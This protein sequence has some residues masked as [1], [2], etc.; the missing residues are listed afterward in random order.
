MGEEIIRFDFFTLK[1]F[2]AV[3]EELAIGKAAEREGIVASAASK[4]IAD[5]ESAL[6]T[7]LLYRRPRGVTLTPAGDALFHHARNILRSLEQM[8][9]ELSEYRAGVKGHVRIFA[10]LSAIVQFLP[11]DLSTFLR[12]HPMVKIDLEERLSPAVV[13]AVA[14][15]QTDV[16]IFAGNIPAPGLEVFPYRTDQLA[17][18]V[19]RDHPLG[20]V[21]GVRFAEVLDC[22]IVG[23]HRGSSLDRLIR[24]AAEAANRIPRIRMHVTSFDAAC[25]M[26]QN[27]LG[28]SI[29]PEGLATPVA[30]AMRIRIIPLRESWATR[31][32]LLCVRAYRSLP[33]TARL[34]VD[35]LTRGEPAITTHEG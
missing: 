11:E 34:L 4:R 35:H 25:R 33:A 16:G 21:P 2:V 27:G 14:E 31:E 9:G 7:P 1:L 26:V 3:G 28:V 29:I 15:S 12:K 13:R 32:I 24:N 19:P 30:R 17:L 10:N 18:V 5:L 22:D 20:C 8:E 23:L 6:G